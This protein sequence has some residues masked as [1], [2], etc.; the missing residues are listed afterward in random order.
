[1]VYAQVSEVFEREMR[2]SVASSPPS[3]SRKL[4][5][6]PS[7]SMPTEHEL[8]ALFDLMQHYMKILCVSIPASSQVIQASHHG[9]QAINGL[10]HQRTHNQAL[11][12][13]DH[14]VLMREKLI[15]LDCFKRDSLPQFARDQLTRFQRCTA[16]ALY[17]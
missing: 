3:C 13:W 16:H 17:R 14:G 5:P 2:I 4:H 9:V 8:V 15:Y 1:M 12:I 10:I 7:Q 11:L 6:R